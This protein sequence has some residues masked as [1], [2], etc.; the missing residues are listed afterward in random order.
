MADKEIRIRVVAEITP[1]ATPISPQP[2]PATPVSPTIPTSPVA[3]VTPPTPQVQNTTPTSMP[4]Q[5]SGF[6]QAISASFLIQSGQKLISASGNSQLSQAIGN[7]VK[8]GTLAMQLFNPATA[9]T[10]G[11]TMVVDLASQA[12]TKV[13]ELRQEA[14]A[15]NQAQYNKILSGQIFLGPGEYTTSKDFW[16]NITYSRK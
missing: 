4:N 2:T 16:G 8:Y 1:N 15:N 6:G 10:A 12:I 11:L 13:N 14:K 5:G 7:T 9:I 3:P